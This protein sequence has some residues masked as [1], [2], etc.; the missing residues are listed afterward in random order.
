[1]TKC[2]PCRAT[3]GRV[4]GVSFLR[5]GLSQAFSAA[6]HSLSP[7]SEFLCW[8]LTAVT[9]QTNLHETRVSANK[10]KGLFLPPFRSHAL[11]GDCPWVQVHTAHASQLDRCSGEAGVLPLYPPAPHPEVQEGGPRLKAGRQGEELWGRGCGNKEI[12]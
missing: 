11:P 12:A 7:C 2:F 4:P 3:S 8:S 9:S 5:S 1:M 10:T 6:C